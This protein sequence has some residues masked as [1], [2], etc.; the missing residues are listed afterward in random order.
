MIL[1]WR[2]IASNDAGTLARCSTGFVLRT[3]RVDA[4]GEQQWPCHQRMLTAREARAW[5][6]ANVLEVAFPKPPRTAG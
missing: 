2:H 6:R 3:A 5:L 4:G 1:G